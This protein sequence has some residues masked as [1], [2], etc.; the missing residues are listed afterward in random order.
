MFYKLIKN[1]FFQGKL[2]I[3][4]IVLGRQVDCTFIAAD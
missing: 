2:L 3:F 4:L 1:I